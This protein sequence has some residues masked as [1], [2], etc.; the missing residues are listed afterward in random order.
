MYR[1]EMWEKGFYQDNLVK[2]ECFSCEKTFIVGEEMSKSCA[3]GKLV[4][5][6]CGQASVS[7]CSNTLDEQLEEMNLGCMGLYLSI[8]E[9][10]SDE[11][12]ENDKD[13]DVSVSEK[14][15]F[16]AGADAWDT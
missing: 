10:K 2:Y 8:E 9:E 13:T 14:A 5:P 4:C 1:T 11:F 3:S 16:Q 15:L 7:W 12:N 6:Y